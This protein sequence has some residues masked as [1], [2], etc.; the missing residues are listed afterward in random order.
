MKSFRYCIAIAAAFFLANGVNAQNTEKY[1]S[2]VVKIILP[3]TA[4]GPGDS[5]LRAVA[6]KLQEK[7]GQPVVIENRP[8]ANEIIGAGTVAKSPPDGYTIFAGTEASLTMN[9]FLYSKL[10]YNT[11]KD[12][13]PITRVL[14]V[15]L[16][17]VVPT[18]LPVKTM[19]DFIS[20]AKQNS[21][22]PIAFASSG[23]GGFNHLP[24]VMLAKNEGF[25]LNYIV[26]KGTAPALLDLIGGTVQVSMMGVGAIETHVKKGTLRALAVASDLRH[27]NLP[28]T[29]TFKELGLKDVGASYGYGLVAPKGTPEAIIKEISESVIAIVKDPDFQK[30][31]LLPQSVIATPYGPEEYG[32]YLKTNAKM[33]KERISVS[34][35]KP[36]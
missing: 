23:A 26:Y 29:P 35:V 16:T 20:F 19:R 12:F 36:N 27:P 15:P 2:R 21:S 34:G 11:E 22:A 18:A 24:A 8:G 14:E 30:Q 31:H 1:P 9:Q 10:P 4:G 13:E 33:Q 7:W 17:V 6:V 28:D 3:Y 5:V 32:R 25:E